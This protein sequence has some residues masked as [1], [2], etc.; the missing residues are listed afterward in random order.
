MT[1]KHV[2]TFV[3]FYLYFNRF[4]PVLGTYPVVLLASEEDVSLM[5]VNGLV[6]SP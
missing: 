6:S 1:M 4:Y 2:E 3:L 5:V